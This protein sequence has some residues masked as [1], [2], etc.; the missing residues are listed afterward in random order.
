MK[1]VIECKTEDDATWLYRILSKVMNR[2]G[3]VV[4][5]SHN[6]QETTITLEEEGALK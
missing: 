5:C 6:G 2:E 3:K 4:G 1:Y